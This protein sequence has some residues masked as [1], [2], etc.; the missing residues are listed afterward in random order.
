MEDRRGPHAEH[1]VLRAKRDALGR[2]V[3][4]VEIDQLPLL[5]LRQAGPEAQVGAGRAERALS[6]S[7]TTSRP[8]GSRCMFAGRKSL[9]ARNLGSASIRRRARASKPASFF[10]PA[11]NG[12]TSKPW[13][14]QRPMASS[15]V[16]ASGRAKKSAAGGMSGTSRRAASV[17]AAIAAAARTVS[18]RFARQVPSA[19]GRSFGTYSHT[20][21][22]P[23]RSAR[24]ELDRA[25]E[26]RNAELAHVEPGQE[27]LQ[28]PRVTGERHAELG[29][30]EEIAAGPQAPEGVLRVLST[31]TGS[32]VLRHDLAAHMT[33]G[34][35]QLLGEESRQQGMFAPRI[36]RIVGGGSDTVSQLSPVRRQFRDPS[37]SRALELPSCARTCVGDGPGQP[38]SPRLRSRIASVRKRSALSRMKPAASRWS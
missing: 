29:E 23:L 12:D 17:T 37:S 21:R 33:E 27:R 3:R 13:R 36:R 16:S 25:E 11:R 2:K 26:G 34:I 14:A 10:A 1:R 19:V 32:M 31:A 4:A 28:P 9:C 24:D 20:I 6:Q 22:M 7:R 18:A 38:A 15:T 5:G 30:D 35:V 8:L